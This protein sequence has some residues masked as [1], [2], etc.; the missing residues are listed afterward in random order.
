MRCASAVRA[1][2]G[3]FGRG[4]DCHSDCDCWRVNSDGVDIAARKHRNGNAKFRSGAPELQVVYSP[5]SEMSKMPLEVQKQ[6]GGIQ[7]V[8]DRGQ[9][10]RK[11][12]LGV[13]K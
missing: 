4:V 10:F 7:I 13:R 8:R 12:N 1:H 11:R 9:T 5:P 6:N 3:G 2:H